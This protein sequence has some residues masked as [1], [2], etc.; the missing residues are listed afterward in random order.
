MNLNVPDD[1]DDAEAAAIAAAVGAHL[2]DRDRAVA[3]AAAAAAA[4]DE[5]SWRGR[6]WAFAGRIDGLQ[7]RSIRVPETAPTDGWTASGRTDRF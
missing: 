1:A 6:K 2:T 7:G 4:G 3:A 5:E